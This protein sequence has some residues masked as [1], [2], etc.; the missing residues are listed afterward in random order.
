MKFLI[1]LTLIYSFLGAKEITIEFLESKPKSNARDFYIWQFLGQDGVKPDEAK[2]AFELAKIK[3]YKIKKRYLKVTDDEKFLKKSACYGLRPGEFLKED[4][5]CIYYALSPYKAYLISKHNKNELR[6]IKKRLEKEYPKE[7]KFAE[8]FSSKYPVRELL[9][10]PASLFLEIFTR[11]GD[12]FRKK[13]LNLNYKEEF[14][15]RLV[16][17][18]RFDDFIKMVVFE[19][20]YEKIQTSL[21]NLKTKDSDHRAN[22]FLALNSINYKKYKEALRYLDFAYNL[23]KRRIDAD[24]SLLWKYLLTKDLKYLNQIANESH[25]INIYSLYAYEKLNLKVPYVITEVVS[26]FKEREDF[27]QEEP[28]SWIEYMQRYRAKEISIEQV[29]KDLNYIN[30]ESHFTYIL[31]IEN[32]YRNNYFIIPYRKYL[33]IYETERQAMLLALARQESRFIPSAISTSYALGLMQIM[34]FLAEHIA[35]NLKEDI[36]LADMLKP[37]ISI[38]Y[39]NYHLN[40]DLRRLS[41][42]LIIAYAYNGGIGFTR[43]ILKDSLFCRDGEFEPFLSMEFVPYDETRDYGKKVLANYVIYRR[44]LGDNIEISKLLDEVKNRTYEELYLA[45]K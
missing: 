12:E 27:I 42:P 21:F 16:V 22:F 44:L 33:K 39:A 20:G 28:F 9:N 25:N 6:E 4:N 31:D 41:H 45:K 24:K 34:P 10:S 36:T 14:L 23:A 19:D 43:S 18:K 37:N 38:R 8:I 40:N 15:N 11:V 32:S 7:T 17:N 13:H 5:R 29:K 35:K 26:N 3:S 2:R 1:A 30:T